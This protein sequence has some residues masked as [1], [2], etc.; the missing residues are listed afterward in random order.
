MIKEN[1]LNPTFIDTI[2]KKYGGGLSSITL[3]SLERGYPDS[4]QMEINVGSISGRITLKHDRIPDENEKDM[5][6][7]LLWK[8]GDIEVK[9]QLLRA[10]K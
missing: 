5:R 6:F 8:A 10:M 9:Q 2:S 3:G 4:V 1:G 7:E